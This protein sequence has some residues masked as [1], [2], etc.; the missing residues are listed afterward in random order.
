[1]R[2]SHSLIISI[3]VLA[4][5]SCK[6]EIVTCEGEEVTFTE[7]TIE[8]LTLGD[9]RV[10]GLRS[11]FESYRFNLWKRLI[12]NNWDVDFIGTR[13]DPGVYPLVQNR[14]FDADHEGLGGET[15]VGL[16]ETLKNKTFSKMPEVVLVGIGGNDL[17]DAG[18]TAEATLNNLEEIID[19]IQGLNPNAVILIEQIAPGKTEFMTAEITEGF[20]AYN[21]GI[22]AIATAKTT[23]NSKVIVIDMAAGFNDGLLA[24]DVHYNEAGAQF[25]ADRYYAAFEAHVTR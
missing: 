15:T 18:A 1:M 19:L 5:Y 16:I 3:L 12:E 7:A 6:D 8:V 2:F 14:C 11:E 24:D 20:L 13:Q 23:S 10:E 25:V 9:S 22:P 4:L 17:A 21:A